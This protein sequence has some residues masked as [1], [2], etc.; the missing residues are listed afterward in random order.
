MTLPNEERQA[1]LDA[2]LDA[3]RLCLRGSGPL[4]AEHDWNGSFAYGAPRIF[5]YLWPHATHVTLGLLQGTLLR[6]VSRRLLGH[7][8]EL[9]TVLVRSAA[10]VDAELAAIVGRAAELAMRQGMN[11][12]RPIRP[13]AGTAR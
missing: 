3:L 10:E 12:S 4:V 5:A 1:R 2:A 13:R 7:G 6:P 9:R 11:G 8:P